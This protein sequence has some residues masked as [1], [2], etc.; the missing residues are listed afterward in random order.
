MNILTLLWNR[1]EWIEMMLLHR[2]L[3]AS[4]WMQALRT[5]L[6]GTFTGDNAFALLYVM[7]NPVCRR[8]IQQKQRLVNQKLAEAL[9]P[10][11]LEYLG[12]NK[13]LGFYMKS[14]WA[15]FKFAIKNRAMADCNPTLVLSASKHAHAAIFQDLN[16]VLLL[17]ENC[18]RDA[19]TNWNIARKNILTKARAVKVLKNMPFRLEGLQSTDENH[20]ANFQSQTTQSSVTWLQ[21]IRNCWK[22]HNRIAPSQ[23]ENQQRHDDAP[24]LFVDH[25]ALKRTFVG[26]N[27]DEEARLSLLTIMIFPDAEDFGFSRD[28][29]VYKKRFDDNLTSFRNAFRALF[30]LSQGLKSIDSSEKLT[31]KEIIFRRISDMIF[32]EEMKLLRNFH[33]LEDKE[34]FDLFHQHNFPELEKECDNIP[35]VDEVLKQL[36]SKQEKSCEEQNSSSQFQDTKD[37]HAD[38]FPSTLMS[39]APVT[40]EPPERCTDVVIVSTPHMT[41]KCP[42]PNLG[43]ARPAMY[44]S[45]SVLS[46]AKESAGMNR[47]KADGS[48]QQELLSEDA[49][50]HAELSSARAEIASLV[51]QVKNLE[52]A[53]QI[54]TANT[55]SKE[56][57]LLQHSAALEARVLVLTA[58]VTDLQAASHI[59]MTTSPSK[60]DTSADI[61]ALSA[62]LKSAHAV[63]VAAMKRAHDAEEELLQLRAEMTLSANVVATM[64]AQ[65]IDW[66]DV[67][68][69]SKIIQA[70]TKSAVGNQAPAVDAESE[71]VALEN[72]TTS[73]NYKAEVDAA[74]DAADP[75][76]ADAGNFGRQALGGGEAAAESQSANS[77]LSSTSQTAHHALQFSNFL[78]QTSI[79]VEDP[80]SFKEVFLVVS[81]VCRCVFHG[82]LIVECHV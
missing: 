80:S 61:T 16:R 32:G 31:R 15:V 55:L 77:K 23:E 48:L 78:K 72:R 58:Q 82:T 1:Y 62:E 47:F 17:V 56:A 67:P 37:T 8:D 81:F 13:R 53:L 42:G 34:A 68:Q 21:Q 2:S 28:C 43:R 18:E 33:G 46:T 38:A 54:Q 9:L 70:E 30:Q 71:H 65:A 27:I 40:Q 22:R 79:R 3:F 57:E 24:K 45:Q 26:E 75:D 59:A 64:A 5:T 12:R 52:A 60:L 25:F 4:K 66:Q 39:S 36:L 73:S 14:L 69:C 11:E 7:Y 6:G 50:V 76:G 63:S 49:I 44:S 51:E 29:K 35:S 10:V 19:Q 74:K 20:D 41:V